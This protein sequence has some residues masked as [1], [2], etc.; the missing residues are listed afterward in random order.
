MVEEGDRVESPTIATIIDDSKVKI[1]FK[2]ALYEAS[3]V[4]EGQ[5]ILL[6]YKKVLSSGN[7]QT[8]FEGFY[9]GTITKLNTNAVPNS[10][11][12]SYIYNGVIEADNPGLVQKGMGVSIY[13]EN[14][15]LPGMTLNYSGIVSSYVNEKKVYST[16][17]SDSD[18]T[19]IIA[20]EVPVSENE[21]VEEGQMLLRIA[22][23]DVTDSIQD[24]IDSIKEDYDKIDNINDEIYNINKKI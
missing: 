5:Q 17:Y 3:Y 8:A 2:I 4:K 16:I 20:T 13:T 9:P 24:D 6:Q 10:D 19:T 7:L 21:F 12:I 11:G 1:S 14:N 23:N 22:G 18:S 15:G